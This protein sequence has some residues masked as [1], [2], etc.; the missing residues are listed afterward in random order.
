MLI[1][2]SLQS[3]YK[4]NA[5]IGRDCICQFACFIFETTVCI[6]IRFYIDGLYYKL[7]E[8]SDFDLLIQ[9]PIL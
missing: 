7:H 1:F 3:V 2:C 4:M 5:I 8:F 9:Y 6:L